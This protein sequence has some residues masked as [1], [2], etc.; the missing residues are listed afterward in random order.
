[1]VPSSAL[2]LPLRVPDR[3]GSPSDPPCDSGNRAVL[4][5]QQHRPTPF[6][7]A[8]LIGQPFRIGARAGVP[9]ECG[10]LDGIRAWHQPEDAT[11]D[12]RGYAFSTTAATERF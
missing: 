6:T 7:I 11:L 4:N 9:S 3:R 12:S 2:P 8:L 1:M 5:Q 10:T